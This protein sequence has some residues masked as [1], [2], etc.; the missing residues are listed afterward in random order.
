M[1]LIGSGWTPS[2]HLRR[3]GSSAVS[4]KRQAYNA[5]EGYMS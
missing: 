1:T 5:A 3:T 2:P 4:T